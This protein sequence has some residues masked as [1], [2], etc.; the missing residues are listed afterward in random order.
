[1]P[2][3]QVSEARAIG[4]EGQLACWPLTVAFAAWENC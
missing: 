2:S 1:V 3:T 4:G